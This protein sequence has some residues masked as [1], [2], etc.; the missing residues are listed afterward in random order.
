[1]LC[2][3]LKELESCYGLSRNR[4]FGPVLD[5]WRAFSHLRGRR[6]QV[7]FLK[8]RVEGVVEDIDDNGALI[9]KD[10]QGVRRRLFS[11]DV[12]LVL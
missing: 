10:D 12:E 5:E 2:R 11:G 8:E 7:S 9:V 4:G 3:F 1:M 6:V